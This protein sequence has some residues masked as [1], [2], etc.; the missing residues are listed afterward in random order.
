MSD[1]K[2]DTTRSAARLEARIEA[3]AAWLQSDDSAYEHN[4]EAALRAAQEMLRIADEIEYK[5]E[6]ATQRAIAILDR[7]ERP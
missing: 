1:G 4:R 6:A 2:S 7:Q 3:A 5:F